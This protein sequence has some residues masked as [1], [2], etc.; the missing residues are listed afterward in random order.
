MDALLSLLHADWLINLIYLVAVLFFVIGLKRLGSP[1]TARQG[2]AL[3]MTGMFIAIV[4]TLF[5]KEIVS[6]DMILIAILSGAVIGTFIARKVAMTSMPEMVALLN[7]FGGIASALVAMAEYYTNQGTVTDDTI[8]YVTLILSLLVGTLTFSGSIV[9]FGKLY[10]IIPGKPLIVTLSKPINI[11]LILG[12]AAAAVMLHGQISSAEY[13]YAILGASIIL[14]ITL[15]IPIGGADMPVVVSL[16]NSYSGIA[17]AMTGFVLHNNA[18]I[19]VGSLVG[20]SG[21]I[22][23]NIMCKAMNRSLANVLFGGFGTGDSGPA[24]APTAGGELQ[25]AK[26]TSP[27]EAAMM[28]DIAEKVIIVPGYGMAVSQAQHVVKKLADMLEKR[29]V[30]VKYAIHPVAG[31]MPGH[32]NVLLAEAGVE[33]DKLYDLEIN[34]EFSR[35]DIVIIIGANDV[36]NPS[37]K[38]DPSCDIYGMPVF[39]V[40]K[41]KT[42]YVL[43]RSLNPGFAGIE[44]PLFFLDNTQMVLGDAKKTVEGFIAALDEMS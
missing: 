24:A 32:M 33:Y 30:D 8:V 39:D 6:F 10:G 16:L 42:V 40:E 25:V 36:V 37:A 1:K 35:T 26:T 23:T 18:L 4:I 11:I 21:I 27:D 43:K 9:A 3:S 31:R 44:N 17:V 28:M 20:A 2:N 19:V 34:D 13:V 38:T 5:T 12:C 41:A 15:V 22:L 7:G 29:G 14:G